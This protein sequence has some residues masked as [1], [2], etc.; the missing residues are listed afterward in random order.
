MTFAQYYYIDEGF[1][2]NL[3][4]IGLAGLTS[5]GSA[6]HSATPSVKFDAP[7]AKSSINVNSTD[8]V[9]A[10]LFKEARGEG[11]KGMEAVNEVIHNRAKNKNKDLT[12]IC[13]QPK[14]FS[15][16]NNITPSSEVIEKI[17]S[18]DPKMF[19]AARKIAA[20]TPTDYT[21]GSLYYHTKKIN[22]KWSDKLKA[23]GYQTVSIGNH[24]FYYK[25]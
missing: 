14:Q 22:P 3:K 25:S 21:N 2:N 11:I 9:A 24:I 15:C 18:S 17:K 6:L 4:A 20:G 19:E 1:K 8:I 13:T 5:I 10:T 23:K 7:S 16:W 12:S